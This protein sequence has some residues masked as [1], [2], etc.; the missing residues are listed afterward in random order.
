MTEEVVREVLVAAGLAAHADE[1]IPSILP[2]LHD[3]EQ[4]FAAALDAL[5]LSGAEPTSRFDPRWE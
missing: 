4:R 3:F 2:I 1:D 5:D